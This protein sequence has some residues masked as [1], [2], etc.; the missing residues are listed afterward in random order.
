MS[1]KKQSKVK[2]HFVQE[3]SDNTTVQT[4][5]DNETY[6]KNFETREK[7]IGIVFKIIY[8]VAIFFAAVFM[9]MNTSLSKGITT[10]YILMCCTAAY[11]LCLL[12]R[13]VVYIFNELKC[14]KL[15]QK[16]VPDT[17]AIKTEQS[18]SRMLSYF[19]SGIITCFFAAM[20]LNVID[21]YI[22]K[23]AIIVAFLICTTIGAAFAVFRPQ[24]HSQLFLDISSILY[25]VAVI[26][27][28][29]LVGLGE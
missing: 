15:N 17:Q 19:I 26:C 8:V 12:F 11:L 9:S 2:A 21:V 24:K 13:M 25:T 14:L 1:K 10:A 20:L 6:S 28:F 23:T 16:D 29:T 27:F 3:P 22:T 7:R 4:A 18:Y 5:L